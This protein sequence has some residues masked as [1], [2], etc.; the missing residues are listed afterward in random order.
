MRNWSDGLLALYSLISTKKIIEQYLY[1]LALQI[2]SIAY[3]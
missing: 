1:L 3:I 2:H